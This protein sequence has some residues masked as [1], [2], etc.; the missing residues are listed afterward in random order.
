MTQVCAV[1]RKDVHGLA[2]IF[3]SCHQKRSA[4]L[5]A[6]QAPEADDI[7]GFQWQGCKE[8]QTP[9]TLF[10]LGATSTMRSLAWRQFSMFG[11]IEPPFAR[12]VGKKRLPT[13]GPSARRDTLG[14]RERDEFS[15][16][17]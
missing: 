2:F 11:E 8:S 7:Y 5:L 3:H 17:P 1:H 14:A 16:K 4:H 6:R 12:D 13:S 10:N 15:A 9:L